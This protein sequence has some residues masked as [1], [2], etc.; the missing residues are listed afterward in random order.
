VNRVLLVL[1]LLGSTAGTGGC[2]AI[3]LTG[4]AVGAGM[5]SAGAGAAVRAG[6]E[7]TR[8]GVV[9]KTFTLSQDQLRTA[10]GDM[11]A[12]MELGVISD[13]IDENGDRRIVAWA[14]DREVEIDLQ[15]ITRTVTRLRLVV[16]EG[17]FRR[18]RATAAEIVAQTERVVEERA[19]TRATRETGA[20]S[21]ARGARR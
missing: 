3:G 21:L 12:H 1:A 17:T 4:A 11:L 20:S 18:D 14:R 19:L 6:T 15:P 2:A 7:M 9:Y 8:G 10:V 16:S 13:M 5:F